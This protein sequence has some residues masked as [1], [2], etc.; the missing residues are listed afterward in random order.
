[1]VIGS[2][3]GL[4]PRPNIKIDWGRVIAIERR[5]SPRSMNIEQVLSFGNQELF[6]SKVFSK[7]A[8]L[9]QVEGPFRASRTEMK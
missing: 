5:H 6:Q 4:Q 7:Q 3:V 8:S 2:S 1:M 9:H